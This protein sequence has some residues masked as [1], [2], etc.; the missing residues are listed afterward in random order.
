VQAIDLV[1]P[2]R[3][4]TPEE[5]SGTLE[6]LTTEL[7]ARAGFPCRCEVKQGE[8]HLIKVVTDDSSAGILIG[9][10][11][12]TVDAV[13]HLVE[14]MGSMA[15]GDRVPMNLD[16]NNYRRRRE[17]A[18]VERTQG[19][20]DKVNSSGREVHM[21]PLSARERRIVHLEVVKAR[22]MRSYTIVTSNGKHVVIAKDDQRDGDE[23]NG[24]ETPVGSQ[25]Q[26]PAAGEGAD[27]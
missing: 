1:Q 6:R 13:E 7:L 14:R 10:R 3:G 9:R 2:L 8:Y 15:A 22:G 27:A 18:L 25:R 24:I 19:L 21:E 23:D 5:V 17:E 12:T 4:V 20:I 16:I 11:G 26:E